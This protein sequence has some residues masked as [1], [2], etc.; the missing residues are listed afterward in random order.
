MNFFTRI[1]RILSRLNARM[2]LVLIA[3]LMTFSAFQLYLK[4]KNRQESSESVQLVTNV[5]KTPLVPESLTNESP[6]AEGMI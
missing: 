3:I 2:I 5:K 6:L 4:D 1:M